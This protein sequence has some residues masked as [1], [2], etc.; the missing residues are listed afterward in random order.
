M[1]NKSNMMKKIGA[2]VLSAAMLMSAAVFVPVQSEGVLNTEVQAASEDKVYGDY[3]YFVGSSGVW[4]TKYIGSAS[5]VVIP[6]NID[7]KKVTDV[8]T[9]AFKNCT[10]VTEVTIPSGVITISEYA[11]SGC[12]NLKKVIIP[13]T[14]H[15]IL[16]HSFLN[17]TALTD[18]TLPKKLETIYEQAFK[19]CQSLTSINIPSTVK[20]IQW[21]AFR[22]CK[23]LSDVQF[24]GGSPKISQ[25]VFFDCPKLKSVTIPSEVTIINAKSFGYY[26]DKVITLKEKDNSEYEQYRIDTD[27]IIRGKAGTAAEKY[28]KEYAVQFFDIDVGK[29]TYKPESIPAQYVTFNTYSFK[30]NQGKTKQL[31]AYINPVNAKDK[32]VTWTSSDTQIATVKNGLVT[33]K[34]PGAAQ[35]TATTVNGKKGIITVYIKGTTIDVTSVKVNKSSATLVKGKTLKL[36]ASVSP[37]NAS[38]KIIT[39]YSSKEGIASVNL[40]DGTVT[41]NKA[42][43]TVITAKSSNGKKATC[44]VTV[45]NPTAAK[46]VKLNKT[47]ITLGKGKTATL[48][49]TV[50]PGNTTDKKVT[51]STSNKNIV[52]VSGGKI[53]AKKVG[54]A[55]ITV[56]TVN[57]KTAKCKVTVKNLPTKVKLNKTSASLKV[58]KSLTLKATV[59]PTKNVISSITWST[60]NKKIATVKNGKVTALKAG[61]VTITAKTA[62][63]K[64]A[65]CKITVKK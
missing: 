5:K 11:F 52:T 45:K 9:G 16:A 30:M 32:T 36:T 3:H 61:T 20:Y 50:S 54:T 55:T 39:W 64:T 31:T 63:G 24:E 42:G 37:S 38:N 4:I 41:A 33:A 25:S 58:K 62:N 14:V 49:A 17:C 21:D 56:K 65:K 40:S 48:K 57:G 27:F 7:G 59:T 22:G 44:T 43:T 6:D 28:A 46:S 35:I 13:D 47:A 19:N 29:V 10:S 2:A 51:W 34:K 18:I 53:T 1:L 26:V 15:H 12:T 8:Y 23:A 60:S